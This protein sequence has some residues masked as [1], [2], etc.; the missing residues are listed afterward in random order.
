[1]DEGVASLT[2]TV[3]R[4]GGSLG[5]VSVDYASSDGWALAGED[6]QATSGTLGFADGETSRSIIVTILNDDQTEDDEDFTL[7]LSNP[8][9][10]A[11]LGAPQSALVTI[12]DDDPLPQPGSLALSSGGY[13]LAEE[14]GS[15][16]LTV[17]RTGGSDGLVTVD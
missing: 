4:T 1:M 9:G 16:Q 2:V 7:T 15:V 6:Y 11:G 5:D 12:L 3:T 8:Q 10:G 14:G 13:S 17:L